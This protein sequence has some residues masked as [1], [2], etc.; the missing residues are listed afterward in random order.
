[1]SCTP[2]IFKREEMNSLKTKTTTL[3]DTVYIGNNPAF[4]MPETRIYT[5][6]NSK[7]AIVIPMIAVFDVPYGLKPLL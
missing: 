7:Y 3:F 4:V 1:M 5:F 2:P 6:C